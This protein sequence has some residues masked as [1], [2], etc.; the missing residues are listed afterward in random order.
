MTSHDKKKQADA[1]HLRKTLDDILNT[2]NHKW[3][4]GKMSAKQQEIRRQAT[5]DSKAQYK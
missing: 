4:L 1:K 5:K 3:F 2:D